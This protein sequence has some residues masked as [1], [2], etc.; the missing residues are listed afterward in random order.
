M[1]R[2]RKRAPSPAPDEGPEE[3]GLRCNEPLT[4][5]PGKAIPVA[6]LLRRLKSLSEELMGNDQENAEREPLVPKAQELASPL[7]LGHRDKG[8]RA[9]TLLCVVEMIRLLAPDAPYKSSQLKDIFTLFIS[10][11]VPALGNLSDPYHQQYSAIIA[12]LAVSEGIALAMDIP[13]SDIMLLTLFTNCFDV[14]SGVGRSGGEDRLPK[15][16]EYYMTQTLQTLVEEGHLPAEVIEIILAQFLRADPNAIDP[17]AFGGDTQRDQAV[18]EAPPAYQMAR[19][20]CQNCPEKMSQA[21]GQYFN[22][23]LIDASDQYFGDKVIRTKG[24][25]R[26]HDESEADS[27]DGSMPGQAHVDLEEIE[28]A[29][30]LLRELWRSAS[31]VVRNIIPSL[32]T[33]IAGE[34]ASLRVLATATIGDMAAGIGAAGLPPS[35]PMDPAAYPPQSLDTYVP[36]QQPR[37]VLLDPTA[38]HA[39]SAVY[40][41][42]YKLFVDRR[43]DKAPAVRARWVLAAA[44]I[45]STSAG[46]TGL[47]VE[48]EDEL[49]NYM[50]KL[51]RD[52]DDRVRLSAVSALHQ[53]DF[54]AV[55]QKL[56]RHGGVSDAGSLLC[57]LAEE[58]TKDKFPP[59]RTATFELLARI[60][61]VA[62]GAIAEGSEH[63]RQ[64]LGAIPSKIFEA[65]Y[66]GGTDID[67]LIQH[68]MFDALL[69]MSYPPSKSTQAGS[70]DAQ[71]ADASQPTSLTPS[72][73]DRLRTERILVLVRD[74][75]ERAKRIWNALLTRQPKI[76]EYLQRYLEAC[77]ECSAKNGGNDEAKSRLGRYITFISANFCPDRFLAT[78]H[79]NKFAKAYDARS[80]QLM[81]ACW[82][83][84]SDHLRVQKSMEKFV[85]R[86][87][88]GPSG[89][90]VVLKTLS[91]LLRSAASLVYNKSHVPYVVAI[92]STNDKGLG[93]AAQEMLKA[94]STVAPANFKAHLQ[95]LC[96]T[97]KKQVP[98]PQFHPELAI[99][100][101]MKACIGFAR[102][103]PG[104]MPQD[105]D[106]YRAMVLHATKGS[107]PK[108]AKH[109]VTVIV[110]SANKKELY[111]K[112]IKKA[113]L[114]DFKYGADNYLT[115]LAAISQLRLLANQLCEDETEKMLSIA[116]SEVLNQVRCTAERGEPEW[117]N[118]ADDELEAKLW[119]LRILVN[120]LR[121]FELNEDTETPDEDLR[122]AA[123]P[124]YRLLNTLIKE[125]GKLGDDKSASPSNHRAH[126]RLA[127]AVHLLK[128][129]CDRPLDKLMLSP[130][131]FNNLSK[132]TQD[133]LPEVRA[134]FL[135]AL[136][137][138][139]GAGKL[140]PRFYTLVFLYAYEPNKDTLETAVTW[141]KARAAMSARANDGI[142]EGSFPRFLSLL[143]HHNDF[144]PDLHDLEGFV[145]YIMF[146]LKTVATQH[147]LALLYNTA[148]KLKTVQDSVDASRSENL[149]ILADMAEAVIR[150]FADNH[151]GWSLQLTASKQPFPS[152]LFAR[153]PSHSASREIAERN[154]LPIELSEEL[155]DMVKASMRP[156]KRKIEHAPSG[157]DKRAKT[158]NGT[159]KKLAVRKTPK[160]TQPRYKRTT[161]SAD[162]V[163]SSER[164]KSTRASVAV[165]YAENEDSE[166]DNEMEQWQNGKPERRDSTAEDEDE[167]A[168][169]GT[170]V[171]CPP[172]SE[173]P[174]P[175][176][177]RP[178]ANKRA[179]AKTGRTREAPPA[180]ATRQPPTRAGRTRGGK[181]EVEKAIMDIPSES[182]SELSDAPEEA[183]E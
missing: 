135:K 10:G 71:H 150:C 140:A 79:L 19:T 12:S 78:E 45:L 146:F 38:P 98:S 80:A 154:Y 99:V 162:P 67:I 52:L 132:I 151:S 170:D 145:E 49:L 109:A 115:R 64:R 22:G 82:S 94:I 108:A 8:V 33:E 66:L 9:Y 91:P 84:D 26:T 31:E 171:Q 163:P 72:E 168:G 14:V 17:G 122:E 121:G 89:R 86:V 21:I 129:S 1:A 16:V 149:Y 47:D 43:Q 177:K 141:L 172:P 62:S 18:L 136:Q 83:S 173:S 100:D 114:N 124:V 157:A 142:I 5:K 69:P 23:V 158:V 134:G 60:W 28:K 180:R 77:E 51:L 176:R 39:F 37:N 120:G 96:E 41:S 143:A 73:A 156:K 164:R 76:Q 20:I 53:F 133:P 159:T 70:S 50:S 139:L 125:N 103:S 110:S 147:N 29:H 13:G 3:T 27:D 35:T 56:C 166:D 34:N 87:N 92:S 88:E 161:E 32:E 15:N 24:K 46:G 54:N 123:D 6:E 85:R 44:R 97:L 48:Q 175:A 61:G 68:A 181:K 30:R 25:K 152:E 107:I 75:S 40:P 182:D 167:Q 183:E 36:K 169:D 118:E 106:F 90:S 113:C 178:A 42:A 131:D 81:R 95:E 127:A 105:R 74:L 130:A 117:S 153:L 138:H 55:M 119:A 101:T 137:K 63:V 2:G 126:L 7:L 116:I 112:E 102:Q 155:E 93:A 4:W 111:V 11:I 57:L 65:R 104:D 179:H 58:R 144:G 59:V 165:S 148:Q 160:P 174:A 128:L